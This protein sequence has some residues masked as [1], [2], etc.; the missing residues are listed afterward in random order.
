[1]VS[2]INDQVTAVGASLRGL[3][4]ANYSVNERNNIIYTEGL[5]PGDNLPQGQTQVSKGTSFAAPPRVSRLMATPRSTLS[6]PG[7]FWPK[8][9]LE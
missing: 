6:R 9:S 2:S 5:A 1:M 3:G 8:G 4:R 7:V